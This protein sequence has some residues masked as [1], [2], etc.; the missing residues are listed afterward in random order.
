MSLLRITRACLGLLGAAGVALL[1]AVPAGA[2][3]LRLA[4]PDGQPMTFGSACSGVGCLAGGDLPRTTDNRGE[5]ALDA[6]PGATIEYRRDAI[7]LAKAP[8]GTASGVLV[9]AGDGATAVLPRMLL[10]GAPDVDAVES[11]LVARLNAARSAEG[12][13]LAQINPRLAAAADLQATWLAQDAIAYDDP[14]AF[15]VGPFDSTIGFRLAE[16]SF[17]DAG[18][19]GEVVAAGMSP[20][21]AVSNWLASPGHRQAIL[22]SGRLLI[23]VGRAAGF[24]VVD[25]HDPCTGCAEA[26][27]GVDAASGAS[28]P[29]SPVAKTAGSSSTLPSCGREQLRVRRLRSAAAGV[30]RLRVQAACLRAGYSYALVVREGPARRVLA[31]RRIPGAGTISMRVR[32]ST[33]A[34]IVRV[35]LKRGRRPILR[36]SLPIR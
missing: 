16:V 20:A 1:G 10:P 2:F 5:I 4:V 18:G 23:G 27:T 36:Q 14:A 15:H 8:A 3:T 6:A 12:L 34:R 9:A 7:T 24:L 17:P 28:P 29:P 33:E 30:L 13:P 31:R 22:A 19:G 11:D 21:E 26:G 35:S 25:T 32:P